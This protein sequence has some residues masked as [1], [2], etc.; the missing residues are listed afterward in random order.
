MAAAA[1]PVAAAYRDTIVDDAV[2]AFVT[3]SAGLGADVA[4][5]AAALSAAFSAQAAFLAAAGGCAKPASEADLSALLAPT[6]AAM[7]TVGNAAS[8]VPPSHPRAHHLSAVGDSVGVLGWVA[9]DTNPVAHIA[10]AAGAGDFF[11][12]KVLMGAKGGADAPAAQAWVAALRGVI[13]ALKAYVKEYHTQGLVWNF[14]S[15]M[16]ASSPTAVSGGG[17]GGGEIAM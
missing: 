16:P 9:V 13:A 8:A 2:L 17:G 4:A 15:K 3:A 7:T 14:A 5:Q 12:Y 10:D 11:L 6:V 1:H